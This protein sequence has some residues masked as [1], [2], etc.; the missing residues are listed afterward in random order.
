MSFCSWPTR[1][2][3]QS[4]AKAQCQLQELQDAEQPDFAAETGEQEDT[5][6]ELDANSAPGAQDGAIS[7]SIARTSG[8]N[9]DRIADVVWQP[10]P[11]VLQAL[12]RTFLK[13]PEPMFSAVEVF[14]SSTSTPQAKFVDFATDDSELFSAI[15]CVGEPLPDSRFW[16]TTF[17]ARCCDF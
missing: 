10:S 17:Q 11:H 12:C 5:C 16:T 1:A 4:R 9:T 7:T 6:G 3:A 14:A 15:S 2:K 13:S 8:G